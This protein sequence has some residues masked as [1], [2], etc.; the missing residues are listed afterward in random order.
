M[1]PHPSGSTPIPSTTA[2]P[3]YE[4]HCAADAA[5]VS[6]HRA[7]EAPEVLPAHEITMM[8][9]PHPYP[10][11]PLLSAG[12]VSHVWHQVVSAIH[13]SEPINEAAVRD[14]LEEGCEPQHV[15]EGSRPAATESISLQGH[16]NSSVVQRVIVRMAV[17]TSAEHAIWPATLIAA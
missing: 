13:S 5:H 14:M 2:L 12:V 11:I 8:P 6:L 3:P 17:A 1:L 7:V 9:S 10:G 4:L 15:R 16:I